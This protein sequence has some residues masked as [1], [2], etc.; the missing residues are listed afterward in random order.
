MEKNDVVPGRGG[1]LAALAH[2][3]QLETNSALKKLARVVQSLEVCMFVLFGRS[4]E[5]V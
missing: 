1:K 3:K 2:S 4:T 5:D